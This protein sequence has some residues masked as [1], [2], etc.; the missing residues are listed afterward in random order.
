[1]R[2]IF[3]DE[4]ELPLSTQT[5][6]RANHIQG[7]TADMLVVLDLNSLLSDKQL[8]IKDEL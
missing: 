4:I 7:V 8:I 6:G 3:L 5:G 1:V 2:P